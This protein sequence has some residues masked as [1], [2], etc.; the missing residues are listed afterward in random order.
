[1]CSQK[2]YVNWGDLDLDELLMEY[3]DDDLNLE[4]DL[5]TDSDIESADAGVHV[6][7]EEKRPRKKDEPVAVKRS[8]QYICSSCHNEYKSPSGLHGHVM[9]QHKDS[10]QSAHFKGDW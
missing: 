8:F 10:Y 9:K 1:M 4:S 6:T 2:D 3:T 7:H 5:D